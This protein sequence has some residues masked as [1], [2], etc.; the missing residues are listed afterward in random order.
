[1]PEAS[2]RVTAGS[3]GSVGSA[4]QGSNDPEEDQDDWHLTGYHVKNP[5]EMKD[6][7]GLKETS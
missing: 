5:E 1:M 4:I 7:Q 3:L 2:G 6:H